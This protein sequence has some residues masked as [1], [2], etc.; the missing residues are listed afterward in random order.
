[1]EMEVRAGAE[2]YNTIKEA[3]GLSKEHDEPVEFQFNSVH[4]TVDRLSDIE[5]I[6]RAY[7]V[8]AVKAHRDARYKCIGPVISINWLVQEEESEDGMF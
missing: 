3:I 2:L 5:M 7:M 1:M 4:I 6:R 8:A